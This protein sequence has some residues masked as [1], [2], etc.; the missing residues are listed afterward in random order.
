M[1]TLYGVEQMISTH[2]LLH[3]I[4]FVCDSVSFRTIQVDNRTC[5]WTKTNPGSET[6]AE[7]RDGG[8]WR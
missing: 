7:T 2:N 8:D 4:D 5:S 1:D 3:I 6:V